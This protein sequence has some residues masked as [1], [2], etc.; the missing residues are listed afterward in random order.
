M[1]EMFGSE[2]RERCRAALEVE[3]SMGELVSSLRT[4]IA[5]E[6][7]L[8]PLP[9]VRPLGDGSCCF[10]V[11]FSQLRSMVLA[12]EFYSAAKQAELV[13]R[14]LGGASGASLGGLTGKIEQ[15]CEE[16]RVRVDGN[17]YHLNP[18]TVRVLE[19]ALSLFQ[20]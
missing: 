7:R 2:M 9:E 14:S 10:V 15:L 3:R 6:I 13:E 12:P 16:K 4:M 19:E 18:E 11:A 5:D 20:I 17:T 1:Q 8:H